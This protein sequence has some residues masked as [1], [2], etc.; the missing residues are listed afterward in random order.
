MNGRH[1]F[2]LG[3]VLIAPLVFFGLGMA[4]VG[5]DPLTE[6]TGDFVVSKMLFGAVTVASVVCMVIGYRNMIDVSPQN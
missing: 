5:A 2:I 3:A 6:I 4:G 1:L